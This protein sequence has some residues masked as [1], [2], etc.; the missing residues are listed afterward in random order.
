MLRKKFLM[1]RCPTILEFH[2]QTH[3]TDVKTHPSLEIP[4]PGSS[5]TRHD[6]TH[7]TP[8]AHGRADTDKLFDL[9]PPSS[10]SS[11]DDNISIVSQRSRLL[12]SWAPMHLA[13]TANTV[14]ACKENV[15]EAYR[16]L[17]GSQLSSAAINRASPA[18]DFTEVRPSPSTAVRDAFEKAWSNWDR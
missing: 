16:E 2:L 4:M 5:A 13:R 9:R 1:S 17:F 15:W 10:R 3:F 7:V 18:K 14:I 12:S 6:R 11:N 8:L